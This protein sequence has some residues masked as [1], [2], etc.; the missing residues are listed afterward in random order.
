MGGSRWAMPVSSSVR[1]GLYRS[2]SPSFTRRERI[3]L[4]VVLLLA[5]AVW[6]AALF[7]SRSS[8]SQHSNGAT[9]GSLQQQQGES[10]RLESEE[11]RRLSDVSTSMQIQYS[12]DLGMTTSSINSPDEQRV[13]TLSSLQALGTGGGDQGDGVGSFGT[14]GE[15][16]P[17]K[18]HRPSPPRSVAELVAVR[19]T[20][21]RNLHREI[22]ETNGLLVCVLPSATDH[23]EAHH[24]AEFINCGQTLSP[25]AHESKVID[26]IVVQLSTLYQAAAAAPAY[27]QLVRR[28][29]LPVLF[30]TSEGRSCQRPSD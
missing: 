11:A 1:G 2:T 25:C 26:C 21:V 13:P 24:V 14:T 15:L 3:L 4:T 10:N 20:C 19:A 23:N 30:T 27:S 9:N 17:P 7:D 18:S 29:I 6:V 5:C 12:D 22:Q 8:R 28:C 16:L